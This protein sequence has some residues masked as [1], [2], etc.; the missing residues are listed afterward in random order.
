MK[1]AHPPILATILLE[2]LVSPPHREAL[3][4]DL[5]E[6][7]RQGR[8]GAWYW[9]QVLGAIAVSAAKDLRDHKLLA[10]RAAVIGLVLYELSAFPVIWLAI[11]L[12]RAGIVPFAWTALWL[13]YLACAVSGW[14]VA[15][16]HPAHKLAMTSICAASLLLF[17][18][19]HLCVGLLMDGGRHQITPQMLV[20]GALL[21]PGRPL[22]ALIGGLTASLVGNTRLRTEPRA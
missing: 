10:V 8:S 20:I 9:R 12:A 7:H 2:R 17:E 5:I 15:Q 18:S 19:V 16:L 3:A 1:H 21:L 11:R 13:P 6:Q 22:S 4:G 14:I